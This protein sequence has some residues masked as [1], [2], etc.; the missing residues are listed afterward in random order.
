MEASLRKIIGLPEKFSSGRIYDLLSRDEAY[1]ALKQTEGKNAVVVFDFCSTGSKPRL[2]DFVGCDF[3]TG[4]IKEIQQRNLWFNIGSSAICPDEIYDILLTDE[5]KSIKKGPLSVYHFSQH[6][7][8]DSEEA[9]VIHYH[10]A[11]AY[12]AAR[13]KT[14]AGTQRLGKIEPIRPGIVFYKYDYSPDRWDY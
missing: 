12:L 2:E 5:L 8:E 13:K 11:L 14:K 6:A 1:K 9:D 3:R 4:I 7:A 10:P